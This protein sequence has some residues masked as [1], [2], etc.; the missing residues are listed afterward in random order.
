MK[1][2]LRARQ[3]IVPPIGDDCVTR[4]KMDAHTLFHHGRPPSRP[5]SGAASAAHKNHW[6]ADARLL[7][8]RG[9]PGHGDK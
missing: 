3:Q 2:Y 6:R 9:K 8:G 4:L 1:P 7:D 5:P